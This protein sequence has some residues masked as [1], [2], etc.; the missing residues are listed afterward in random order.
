[1]PV[2]NLL[3]KDLVPREGVLKTA[4]VL[5]KV[6]II[7][8]TGLIIL[9]VSLIAVFLVLS[10]RYDDSIDRQK[11]LKNQISALEQ[12]EVRLVLVKDRLVKANQVLALDS[13]ES[14]MTSLDS[15]IGILPD[16]IVVET[17]DLRSAMSEMTLSAPNSS[18]LAEFLAKLISAGIYQRIEL[19]SLDYSEAKGY[20]M[21]FILA[22]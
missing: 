5:K 19:L 12:T 21:V 2:I 8:F 7:G 10:G 14:E 15:L 22:T 3:P 17:A 1:M 4:S 6:L 20:E 16:G 9:I 11:E 18:S 13:A